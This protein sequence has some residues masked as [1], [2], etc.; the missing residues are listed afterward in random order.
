MYGRCNKA[1][2][3]RRNR[4]LLGGFQFKVEHGADEVGELGVSFGSTGNGIKRRLRVGL[5]AAGRGLSCGIGRVGSWT[6]CATGELGEV[7]FVV[8]G[9]E[10]AC[11]LKGIEVGD[12][13]DLL[14][15]DLLLGETVGLCGLEDLSSTQT[16]LAPAVV[17]GEFGSLSG[18]FL[19]IARVLDLIGFLTAF[20]DD[21]TA[22]VAVLLL[23]VDD[24]FAFE[25]AVEFSDGGF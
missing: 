17:L 24:A 9:I 19:P 8:M 21:A 3:Y 22:F 18:S 12:V 11:F 7:A 10:G 23:T 14:V 15:E 16:R 5:S 25:C 20:V 4:T 2:E 6:V 13:I 1:A